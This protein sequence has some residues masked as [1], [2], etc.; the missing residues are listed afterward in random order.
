MGLILGIDLCDDY[1]QISVFD[2]DQCDALAVGLGEEEKPLIPTMICKKKGEESWLIG[3]Q[4]YRAALYGEGSVVDRLVNLVCRE[5]T[6][7][8]EG[9]LYTAK[10]LLRLYVEQIL[11]IPMDRYADRSVESL[12]YTIRET[13]AVVMD[14]LMEISEMLG[15]PRDRVHILNLTESFLFYVLSQKPEIW[16]NEVCAFELVNHGLHYYE[17]NVLRG[18]RPQIVEAVHEQLEEGFSL[19]ILDTPSGEKMADRILTACATRRM[20][21]KVISTVFLTGKGFDR[22]DW[23]EHF[24]KLV[25]SQR[26]VFG[27]QNLFSKCAAFVAFD[28]IGEV[29]AYPYICICEGRIQSQVSMNVRYEGRARQLVVAS[30]GSNWYETKASVTLVLDDTDRID[31]QVTPV[32]SQNAQTLSV[33]LDEFPPRPN[34]TTKV[35]MLVSFTGERA[36]TVRVFDRGFGELYPSSGKM[37]RRD[38][39]I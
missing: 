16:A 11:A 38:F 25:C 20:A 37:V 2:R 13:D 19:E 18:R 24:L 32:G 10:Q 36:M 34:K 31:L 27:V 15:V 35:E 26:R 1:T 4:A 39:H 29:T 30:A 23:A 8:I 3:E 7:T 6:A 22:T 33:P 5:G 9:E 17:F 14:A 21:R 12:V 28:R